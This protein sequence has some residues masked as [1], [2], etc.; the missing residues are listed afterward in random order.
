MTK[1]KICGITN[2]ED[3]IIAAEAGADA[4][5]VIVDVPVETPRKV[6]IEKAR[7]IL[8]SVPLFV[9]K[10]IVL[11]PESVEYV[12]GIVDELNL[13]AIQLHGNEPL[14]FISE[15]KKN[16]KAKIIKVLHV[17]DNTKIN[18]IMKYA[19]ISDA[20]LIDTKFGNIPGGTG[21]THDWT[22]SRMICDMI[23]PTPL[24]L[25]GGLNPE[26]VRNAINIVNPYAVDVSSGVE[27]SPGKKDRGN[28]ENFVN[29]AKN[30][31]SK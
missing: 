3:A 1:V 29:A 13:D 18:Y 28:T 7:E 25:S 15:L 30:G 12:L 24:I 10:V 2:S 21:K 11:M 9:S 6:G 23:K 22:K 4:I 17:D 5:G 27:S 14:D 20:I 31:V 19:E 8:T 16:I 26:N